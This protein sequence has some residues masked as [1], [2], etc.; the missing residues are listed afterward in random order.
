MFSG[1]SVE[2]FQCEICELAK[3]KRV[4]FLINSERT[5][6]P[7]NLIN[8]NIWGPAEVPNVSG[9][10]W[11][12]TFI[13][14]YSRVTWVFLLKNKSDLSQVILEFFTMIKTQFGVNIKR[15]RSDN[16]PDYFNHMLTHFFKKEGIIHKSSCVNTPQ[17]NGIAERKNWHLDTTRSFLLQNEVPENYWGEAILAATYLINRLPTRILGFKSPLEVLRE[18]FP[19][20]RISNGLTPRI[21]GCICF[22]HINSGDRSKLYSRALKCVF[23][24]YSSTQKG[25]KCYQPL[26]KLN[27]ILLR[28][29]RSYQRK[30]TM[31]ILI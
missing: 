3:H 2:D 9:S 25:Y 21:F 12:V 8:S 14:D 1:I 15:F 13:D 23:V 27:N 30:V 31:M 18:N 11:F 20:L 5:T 4:S 29:R 7:F 17:Q 19:F 28:R 6:N 24:G 22:V 26:M 10:R 16:A